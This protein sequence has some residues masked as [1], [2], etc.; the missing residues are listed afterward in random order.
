MPNL[1]R[2]RQGK[3]WQTIEHRLRL[4]GYSVRDQLLSPHNFGVPQIR[5]RVFIVGHRGGLNGFSWPA[6]SPEPDL[7]I[8]SVLDK[9]PDDA[10]R[11][12]AHFM[13][14]LKAWQQFLDRFP[15]NEELPSFP[16]WAMEF[17]ATYPYMDKSPAGLGLSKMVSFKGSF[18]RPLRDLSAQDVLAALPAYAR[19]PAQSFPK[20]KIDFIHQNRAFYKDHKTWIDRWLPSILE[21]C[22]ELSEVRM[23]LQGGEARYL[24]V[25]YSVSCFRHSRQAPDDS[26]LPYRH[27][28]ESGARYCLGAPLYDDSGV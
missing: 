25:R 10:R 24:A 23:E 1:V 26:P 9:R 16:I 20:W 17:G 6:L 15:E 18:G 28:Y 5:E 2:H 11:L 13:R 12:P 3:T 21:F 4:A 7:S 14:Y 19:D 22:P 8:C 27:D